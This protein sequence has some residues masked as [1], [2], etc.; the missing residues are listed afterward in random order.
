MELERENIMQEIVEVIIGW[1]VIGAW[2]VAA[3][4]PTIVVLARKRVAPGPTIVV[5]V[6]LGW[7]VI[8]WIVALAMA[9]GDR[10]AV[11]A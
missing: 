1:H 5:N 3:L 10:R 2:I 4:L 7:T 9:L 11:T 8:G 6:F